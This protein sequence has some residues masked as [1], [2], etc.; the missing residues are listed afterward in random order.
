MHTDARRRTAQFP[1]AGFQICEQNRPLR[2]TFAYGVFNARN[3][4]GYAS[5][6]DARP[7]AKMARVRRSP[8]SRLRKSENS[9]SSEW[10]FPAFG[11]LKKAE[12]G[13]KVSSRLR[14]APTRQRGYKRCK[15]RVISCGVS[16][17]VRAVFFAAA[18]C[19]RRTLCIRRTPE[20]RSGK[21]GR[22]SA[23]ARSRSCI[24]SPRPRLCRAWRK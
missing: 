7:S 4:R 8:A 14:P 9:C 12:P 2:R 21:G 15:R 5:L 13:G 10:N 22:E 17:C 16:A 24:K 18:F 1:R 19:P 11:A 23:P 3:C 20:I 6:S